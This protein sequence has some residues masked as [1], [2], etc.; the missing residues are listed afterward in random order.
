ME[1]LIQNNSPSVVIARIIKKIS[2]N[3]YEAEYKGSPIIVTNTTNSN[4]TSGL[5]V[6]LN[7]TNNGKYIIGVFGKVIKQ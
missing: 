2:A 7:I 5:G 3:K 4:I 6:L 1:N